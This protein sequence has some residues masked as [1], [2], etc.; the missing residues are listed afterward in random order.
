MIF[1]KKAHRIFLFGLV[2]SAL[3]S[4]SL[5]AQ[6]EDDGV[7][8]RLMADSLYL[9]D[10]LE[11]AGK[12]ISPWNLNTTVGTSVAF[13]PGYGAG[14]SFYAAPHL[15]FSATKR[16]TLHG[17]FV[18]SYGSPIYSSPESEFGKMA[19]YANLSAF[20]AASYRLT[21]D[22]VVYGTGMKSMMSSDMPGF[23]S[24]SALDDISFGAAYSIGNF[25][26]GASFHSGPTNKY[27]RSPF[28][29]GS[30]F[31]PSPIFW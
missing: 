6:S 7:A 12:K 24:G 16:L 25:T 4:V 11:L 13:T 29:T 17:G 15:D 8:M 23:N 27:N 22:L 21:D 18:A 19:S 5:F 1:F 14:S 31:Y 20:V 26:I 3:L 10:N 2:L 28:N 30:G 9:E